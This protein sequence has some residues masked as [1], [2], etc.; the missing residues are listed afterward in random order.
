MSYESL[1]A[2]M[3]NL[4]SVADAVVQVAQ[5]RINLLNDVSQA[6]A[7]RWQA[8]YQQAL[9]DFEEA[10]IEV[11]EAQIAAAEAIADEAVPEI[12]EEEA[13]SIA[14]GTSDGAD[15]VPDV[16]DDPT[17]D[18][19][20]NVQGSDLYDVLERLGGREMNPE[21]GREQIEEGERPIADPTDRE[22]P[23]R[24][25]IVPDTI[26]AT[27]IKELY[28]ALGYDPNASPEDEPDVSNINEYD[29]YLGVPPGFRRQ[30]Y[31][32]RMIEGVPAQMGWQPRQGETYTLPFSLPGGEQPRITPEVSTETPVYRE[33]DIRDLVATMSVVD[34]FRYQKLARDAGFYAYDEIPVMGNISIDDITIIGQVMTASNM[35]SNMETREFWG[36]L[37]AYA[38]TGRDYTAE[39]DKKAPSGSSGYVK[40][41]FSVPG[42][43][44]SIPGEK[45]VAEETKA[46]FREKVG[47][48]PTPEELLGI[49]DG[50]TGYYQRSNEDEIA[51][52]LAAYN[53]DNQGL[54]T[55]AQM[56]RIEDPAA[57]TS[58]DIADKWVDEI[59]L[60]KRRES[61]GDTFRRMLN[62]TMGGHVSVGS[63]TPVR[64]VTTI[65]RGR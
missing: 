33:S 16:K 6:N 51:L 15:L 55:G 2:S 59:D 56:E 35:S 17:T 21:L 41:P 53:G 65:Q 18:R 5:V 3:L 13:A 8:A 63:Q 14:D 28:T 29:P 43:L 54:L 7:D 11:G 40:P 1:E 31:E 44:R 64:G 60:N 58:F 4:F 25:F 20:E 26:S 36:M 22:R 62:A 57:A 30:I 37:E 45:T 50:L 47:R 39:K 34:V 46:R 38:K 52:Y 27:Q 19:P 42:H 32:P 24:E 10:G 23:P 61:N 9:D 12:T 48:E 49:A